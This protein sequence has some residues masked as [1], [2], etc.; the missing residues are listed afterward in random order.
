MFAEWTLSRSGDGGG[1]C[2]YAREHL[3]RDPHHRPGFLPR[4]PDDLHL[5]PTGAPVSNFGEVFLQAP[6]VV[7]AAGAEAVI[8]VITLVL[9]CNQANM[10]KGQ[11]WERT[12]QHSN[13]ASHLL[14][15]S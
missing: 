11:R 2:A 4:D 14:S 13:P 3:V 7:G 6:A 9:V 8:G 12:R 1:V 15:P 5:A 10:G